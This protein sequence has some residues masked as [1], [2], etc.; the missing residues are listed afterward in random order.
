MR[1]KS[2]TEPGAKMWSK[3]DICEKIVCEFGGAAGPERFRFQATTPFSVTSGE[4]FAGHVRTSTRR[5]NPVNEVSM[6]R[7]FAV[8]FVAVLTLIMAMSWIGLSAQEI[9]V[10]QDELFKAIKAQD[11]ALFGAVNRCDLKTL[12]DMVTEDLEFYHDLTGLAVGRTI[13]IESVKSNLCGKVT[14]ELIESSLEV[15]PLKG[16]G[17]VEIGVHHFHHPGMEHDELGEARFV[18]LWQLKDGVW[19]LS[20]VISFEHGAAK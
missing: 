6:T 18:H 11:A 1:P 2:K 5:F 4:Q 7:R 3:Y 8:V 19:R 13:F 16:Y 9:P 12:G 20:R 15:H 10:G 17:A 14:R